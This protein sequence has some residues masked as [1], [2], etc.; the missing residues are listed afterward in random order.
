MHLI[1]RK[2][3]AEDVPEIVA[4]LADDTL[5]KA[6]EQLGVSSLK[7]YLTAFKEIAADANQELTV[8]SSEGQLVATFHLTFL[9]YLTHGGMRR[10]QVE[11]VRTRAPFRNAGIGKKVFEY[12]AQRA[13]AKSCGM[14][15]LT[16]DKQRPKAIAFYQSLGFVPSH[17][18]MKLKF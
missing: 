13:R 8:V 10:C 1:F 3:V 4:M 6:R 7:T 2:A 16:T 9:Q 17:E 5:G 14:V 15:Q 11:A 18:G 12:I